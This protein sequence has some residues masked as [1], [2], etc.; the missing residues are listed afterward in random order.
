MSLFL[1][2][3][4]FLFLKNDYLYFSN[5]L[6]FTVNFSPLQF[7]KIS[8]LNDLKSFNSVF[9]QIIYILTRYDW[10][11]EFSSEGFNVSDINIH[12]LHNL[13][14][15][16]KLQVLMMFRMTIVSINKCNHIYWFLH[17]HVFC[18]RIDRFS[19]I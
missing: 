2:V 7:P 18:G 8:N 17:K 4:P 16:V 14:K 15:Q 11:N 6:F 5:E 13:H 3:W 12:W 1:Q 19:I 10:S 9:F